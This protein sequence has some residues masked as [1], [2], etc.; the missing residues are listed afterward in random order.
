MLADYI[1]ELYAP[2]ADRYKLLIENGFSRAKELAEWKTSIRQRFASMHIRNIDIEGSLGDN[3]KIG[4]DMIIN[5]E[6]SKGKLESSEIHAQLVIVRDPSDVFSGSRYMKDVYNEKITYRDM[7]L[8]EDLADYVLFRCRYTAESTG[9]FNFGIRVM[10]KHP[11]V[12]DFT[13]IN[14]V[15]WG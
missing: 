14:L 1:K 13:D 9:K 12:D 10:P 11:L 5:L 2:S 4:E 3:L 8:Q 7:Q 6:V 15:Y